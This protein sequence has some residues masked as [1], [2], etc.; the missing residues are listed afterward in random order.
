MLMQKFVFAIVLA[1]L[2]SIVIVS[3]PQT[4]DAAAA[5]Y[6]LKLE[7]VDGESTDGKHKGWIEVES[8][9][10]GVS[11]ASSGSGGGA[12]KAKFADF[13][14]IKK[15]DKSSPIL[16]IETATGKHFK[17]AEITVVRSG[18][19]VIKWK[20]SDVLISSY[21]HSGA[22]D[23]PTEQISLNFAKIEVEYG[24]IKMGWDIKTN[25]RV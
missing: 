24:P 12:G 20:L 19:D 4:A 7:G 14:F 6:F 5:D 16:M 11:Q 21:Q 22:Q 1:A 23:A 2:F 15:V 10:F 8:F 13:N 9:S 3:N 17:S 25:K 18:T